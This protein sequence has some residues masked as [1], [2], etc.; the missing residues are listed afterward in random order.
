MSRN[1]DIDRNLVMLLTAC[2]NPGNVHSIA[3]RDPDH[4]NSDF[5]ENEGVFSFKEFM[6]KMIMKFRSKYE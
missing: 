4:K 5:Y 3:Q 2:I 1:I 6:T